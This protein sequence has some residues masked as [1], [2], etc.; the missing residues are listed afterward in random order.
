MATT[1]QLY[2]LGVNMG[3][4]S[5]QAAVATG[6]SS[7]EGIVSTLSLAASAL[8]TAIAEE[9]TVNKSL[10][11]PLLDLSGIQQFANVDLIKSATAWDPGDLATFVN[12]CYNDVVA[13]RTGI[14]ATLAQDPSRASLVHAYDLGVNIAIAEA[15]AAS[16]ATTQEVLA[17]LTA[18]KPDALALQLDSAGLDQCVTLLT[19][20]T[21]RM[22]DLYTKILAV[23]SAFQA[24]LP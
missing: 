14:T 8:Y 11:P 24:S 6:K 16:G 23:R 9:T 21:V 19:D 4:A 22:A 7:V 2:A 12:R 17:N 13:V 5:V 15:D 18:A 20:G 1:G 10:Q 3:L